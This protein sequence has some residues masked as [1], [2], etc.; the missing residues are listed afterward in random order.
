MTIHQRNV[1]IVGGGM[2]GLGAAVELAKDPSVYIA[3]LEAR[4]RLGGRIVTHRNLIP[5]SFESSGLVPAGSSSLAF[6]FG[7]S[8]IHG[9]D[10]SNPLFPLVKQGQ[11][12]YIHTD[13]D[14]MFAKPGPGESALPEDES[15]HYWKV[16]WDI[17]DEG[18]KYAATYRDQIP[19]DLSLRQW[20][21]DYVAGHQSHDPE[22]D[23][24]MTETLKRV[25]PGL[26]M[27]WADENAIPLEQVSMKY[28][29]A[30]KIFPG[31]HSLVMNG[32]DRVIKVLAAQLQK[33]NVRVLLKYIVDGIEYNES[34]VKVSTNHGHFHA[35]QILITLPLGVLK[36][37]PVTFF[38]PPLPLTKQNA[39]QKLGFGTM[40][41][42]LLFFPSCFWPTDIHFINCL[43]SDHTKT[44]SSAL[45]SL[46]NLNTLQV[47]ALKVLMQD[48]AN[49]SSLMPLYNIPILIGYATNL[50]AEL[51]ERLSDEQAR[52]VYICHL[53]HYYDIITSSQLGEGKDIWPKVSFMS[54]WNQDPF[55]RGS[56]TSIPVGATPQ[57]I[58][59]FQ[60][61]IGAKL[62]ESLDQDN[63]HETT[64]T[65]EEGAENITRKE[66][67]GATSCDRMATALMTAVD[68]AESG[69]V[70]FA[71]EHT[72][73]GHFASIQGALMSGRR[74]A[75]KILSQK[76][77]P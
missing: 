74:E 39:I 23:K 16:V 54:G 29:D 77:S 49:Y 72:S 30:E 1:I 57:D 10:P 69:R 27:Y 32:F 18:Q 44:P 56:Y 4:D 66:I 73:S 62:Y 45:I 75:A 52:Q 65:Q 11:I 12:E 19:E 68:D 8:W 47:Q 42:I 3:L 17:L 59:A 31:D 64:A 25:I 26:A 60:V 53:A 2:A 63:D 33:D 48:L 6:D 21:T 50:A 51:M 15:N 61:P 22:G 28:M 76:I 41:K 24:Y 38:S 13:S 14:I 5:T 46:F 40:F 58:E 34:G 35:D 7:A 67:D 9:V 37:Q 70:F 43:P 71:G 55:A 36:S 20:L